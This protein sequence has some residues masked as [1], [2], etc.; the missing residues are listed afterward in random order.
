MN[1]TTDNGASNMKAV[2]NNDR[3]SAKTW[4]DREGSESS[5]VAREIAYATAP[6]SKEE[7]R[8]AFHEMI[9]AAMRGDEARREKVHDRIFRSMIRLVVKIAWKTVGWHRYCFN[10]ASISFDDYVHEGYSALHHAIETFSPDK[11]AN[12][13]TWAHTLITRHLNEFACVRKRKDADVNGFR[14][15]EETFGDDWTMKIGDTFAAPSESDDSEEETKEMIAALWVGIGELSEKERDRLCARYDL[16]KDCTRLADIAA[17]YGFTP[18]R[19]S[20]I[21]KGAVAKLRAYLTRMAG[22]PAMRADRR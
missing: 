17:K 12:L 11:G 13:S 14:S 2:K 16:G 3:T 18:A 1:D 21:T 20:Q 19:A 7:T 5:M 9:A 10:D 8:A 22:Q 6:L 15:L 4:Q